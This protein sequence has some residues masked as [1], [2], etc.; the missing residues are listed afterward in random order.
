VDLYEPSSGAHDHDLNGGILASG[1]FWTLPAD[2]LHFSH[3]G[4][5]AV[6]EVANV[7]VIDSFDFG[8]PAVVEGTPGVVSLRVK[9]RATGPATQRG[10]ASAVPPTDPAAFVGQFAVGQSSAVIEGSEFG[11]SFRSNPD[12]NT[13]RT[14]AEIGSESNGSFL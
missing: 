6:L 14:F 8:N 2:E 9:W 4:G 5:R 11:F 13:T 12:V 10:K 3:D 7:A 1:L